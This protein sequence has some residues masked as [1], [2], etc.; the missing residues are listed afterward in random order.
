VR[1]LKGLWEAE[2]W[3]LRGVLFRFALAILA[4]TIGY[5]ATGTASRNGIAGGV[6][7]SVVVLILALGSQRLAERRGTP[8]RERRRREEWANQLL[9]WPRWKQ[10]GVLSVAGAFAVTMLILSLLS[11]L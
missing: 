6:A 9:S 7:G 5:I 8:E 4:V 11:A 10:I 2:T 3:S 1:L